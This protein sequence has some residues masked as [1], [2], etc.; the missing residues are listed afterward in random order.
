MLKVAAAHSSAAVVAM[1]FDLCHQDKKVLDLELVGVAL[2]EACDCNNEEAM[3]LLLS[4]WTGKCT[5][6]QAQPLLRARNVPVAPPVAAAL[7][8]RRDEPT[9]QMREALGRRRGG[10]MGARASLRRLERA[11]ERSFPQLRQHVVH[12]EDVAPV[13]APAARDAST[14]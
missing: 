10:W 4:R 8:T 9:C 1:L 5:A 11:R 3:Q 2:A 14:S 7:P 12:H 6:V 13:V